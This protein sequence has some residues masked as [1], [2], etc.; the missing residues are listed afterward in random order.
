MCSCGFVHVNVMATIQRTV[1]EL[2]ISIKEKCVAGE[3]RWLSSL[4][5][6]IKAQRWQ[7]YI[8]ATLDKERV[9]FL[10]EISHFF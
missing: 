2:F 3:V 7:Y 5:V 4:D 8:P 10:L 6:S 9:A 1:S